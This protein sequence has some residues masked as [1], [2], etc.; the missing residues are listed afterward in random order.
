MATIGGNNNFGLW[1]NGDFRDGN[2]GQ[3]NFGTYSVDESFDGK[4]CVVA[5]GGGG[6]TFQGN[7]YEVDTSQ[8]YQV[9]MYAKTIQRGSTNNDLAGGHLGFATYDENKSFIDLRNCKGVGDTTLTRAATP[10]DTSIYVANASGWSTST[11]TSQ[12][13]FILFG[14]IYPYSGGYSRYTVSAN[15]YPNT[16]L[17]NL[18]GGEWRIDLTSTLPNWSAALVNGQYPVGTYVSNG[19]AGGTYNYALGA[20]NYPETWTR[21]ATPPF[22]GEN[23]NSG[24]PFRYG[25]KFIRP[26][27]LKNYN[28]RLDSPQDHQWALDRIFFGRCLNGEDYRDV[29]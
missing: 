7:Y 12:R 15:F 9:I 28:N 1:D 3:F 25:T 21:Y 26:M 6:G 22:T 17:T 24:Y 8:T 4:G 19:R 20:P 23:R 5:T 29:L 2:V 14:G 18:G 10:G 27:V 11:T 13:A 16:G